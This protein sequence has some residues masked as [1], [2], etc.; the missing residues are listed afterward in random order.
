MERA[1]RADAQSLRNRPESVGIEFGD[2][3]GSV[4]MLLRG[5]GGDGDGWLDRVAVF[6][7][8]DRG[9]K[10]DGRPG[11]GRGNYSGVAASGH[12]GSDGSHRF[13][14]GYSARRSGGS[15]LWTSAPST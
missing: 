14:C 13:G 7:Q 5:G 2:R 10:T 6:D 4:V 8:R 9:D 11:A 12:G 15:E 1:R 3:R